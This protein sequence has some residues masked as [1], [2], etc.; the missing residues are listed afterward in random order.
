MTQESAGLPADYLSVPDRLNVAAATVDRQVARGA[1]DRVA[2]YCGDQRITYRELQRRVNQCGN[3][4]SR[5][6]IGQGD[7][8]FIRSQNRPEYVITA[9][10]GFKIGAVPIPTNSLFR[11]WEIENLV[12]NSE[13]KAAFTT[14]DLMGPIEEVWSHC[15]SL[16]HLVMFGSEG[17]GHV[18]FDDLVAGASDQLT[19]ADTAGDD[20]AFI[21]YTSGTT[22]RP[23]GVE[24][25]H[26]W[27]VG[28]GDPIVRFLLE[29]TPED[30]VL[31]PLEISFMYAW[32]CAFLYPLYA[33]CASVLYP[34]RFDVEKALQAV[35]RYRPTK[36]LA[37]PTIYRMILSREGIERDYD[38]SS[39]RIAISGGEPLPADT[40]HAMKARFGIE[41]WDS[42]GQTEIHNYIGHRTGLPVKTGSMGQ[43]FPGHVVTILDDEGREVPV[44]TVGHLV[45][46][47]D[48]PGLARRYRKMEELWQQL[49]R[50]GWFYT[51]DLA[52]KD[53]D[54]YYW[55]VSRSDDLIK[56][57]AYLISPKEV[58]SAC[59]LTPAVLEAAVVGVPD[60]EIGQRV[61]A[62]ITLKSGHAA[63]PALAAEIIEKVKTVIAPYKAPKDVEFVAELPKT[64]TGKILRRELRAKAAS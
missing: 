3:A 28:T 25:A 36:F 61:K 15:P 21:I 43:A 49:N 47:N 52:Y 26:R 46:R 57:R 8:F 13:A 60:P 5:I 14:P 19:A 41:V 56:S 7:R 10:A 30:I 11:A 20:L 18:T 48:D 27:L 64:A 55:Y 59:M 51:G 44:G 4:L 16:K 6:G 40:Y 33:G 32:G 63:S 37:V 31:S 9:L 54:G 39:I 38:L 23:K 58:E 42:I 34:A 1:G 12:N 50:G 53:A 45:I 17:A 22:G 62:Y 29:L 24:H 2:F 35:Q